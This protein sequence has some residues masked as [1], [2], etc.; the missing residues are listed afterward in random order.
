MLPTIPNA[1]L[2]AVPSRRIRV[3]PKVLRAGGF[4]SVKERL[5]VL[6][7]PHRPLVTSV[8][9]IVWQA[10]AGIE[11]LACQSEHLPRIPDYIIALRPPLAARLPLRWLPPLLFPHATPHL[12]LWSRLAPL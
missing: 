6:P 10:S 4:A 3:N 9:F 5:Y 2:G 7:L 11:E 1:V 8:L 12:R